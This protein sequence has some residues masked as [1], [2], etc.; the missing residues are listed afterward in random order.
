MTVVPSRNWTVPVAV[1]GVTVTR[2]LK[3]PLTGE[4]FWVE[5]NATVVSV[6]TVCVR[7]AEVDVRLR[8][9]PL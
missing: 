5:D 7:V 9:S 1:E 3:A 8:A 2:K 4:G 6:K